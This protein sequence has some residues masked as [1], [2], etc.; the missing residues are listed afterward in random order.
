MKTV[1]LSLGLAL[2]CLL[3]VEAEDLGIAGLDK[4]KIAG[5][6]YITATASESKSQFQKKEQ[7]KMVKVA[8]K[9]L[10]TGDVKGTF[11]FSTPN[12]C[13]GS[14]AVFKETGIPG[15][16]YSETG[17][18]T[19][20]VLNTDGETYAVIFASRVIDGKT[21]RMMK[22]YSRTPEVRPEIMELFKELSRQKGYTDDMINELISHDECNIDEA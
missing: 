5:K 3:H 8:F 11:S 13:K 17:N 18:K 22:L 7:R 4:S 14:T 15:E 10:E 16:Y 9:I 2:L 20:R 6:W 19:V 21:S 12:G 1:V